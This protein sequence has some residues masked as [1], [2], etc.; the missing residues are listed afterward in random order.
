MNLNGETYEHAKAIFNYC[1]RRRANGFT[2]KL[3]GEPYREW[4]ERLFGVT[5]EE[6]AKLPEPRPSRKV[7]SR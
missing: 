4:F 3:S 6:F 7:V 5:P 1:K 2:A